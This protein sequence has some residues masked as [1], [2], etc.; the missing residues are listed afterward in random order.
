MAKRPTARKGLQPTLVIG[1][2]VSLLLHQ[3]LFIVFGAII[4]M[5]AKERGATVDVAVIDFPNLEE[6][7]AQKKAIAPTPPSKQPVALDRTKRQK[8][9][10][11]ARLA[12]APTTS[13]EAAEEESL[14]AEN[15]AI[16]EGSFQGV[17]KAE[18]PLPSAPKLDL[19]WSDFERAFPEQAAEREA[20]EA[21][22]LQRRGNPLGFGKYS[23]MVKKALTTNTGWVGAGNQEQLGSR[24]ETFRNYIEVVHEEIHIYF[25]DSFLASLS[26]FSP[27]DPLNNFMLMATT[28]FEILANGRVNEVRVVKSSGNAVFDAAAVD[29]I[30]RGS[31]YRPPPKE[32]LSWN[33][34]LYLR[35]GFYRNERKCGAFN[36]E[37]Y[38][39]V[40]PGAEKQSIPF[41]KFM[42]KDG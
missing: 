17:P 27:S 39:L 22:A 32:I 36:A 10:P 37:P 23:S 31:P 14:P 29:S 35:W 12:E 15:P 38:I 11:K 4:K 28:E 8:Q 2:L 26:V 42:I 18:Q 41:D 16:A 30:L 13:P 21:S 24:H 7:K 33:D 40:A 3:T 20:F 25:A 34:R 9:S 19:K 1:L 6:P 5:S